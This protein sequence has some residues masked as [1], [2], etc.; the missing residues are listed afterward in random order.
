MFG[1]G[2]AMQPAFRGS[3]WVAATCMRMLQCAALPMPHLC[4]CYTHLCP[5]VRPRRDLL[6]A[7]HSMGKLCSI[8]VDEAHCV[9]EWGHGGCCNAACCFAGNTCGAARLQTQRG[10]RAQSHAPDSL[11][12]SGRPTCSWVRC[13]SS[14][15]A[16]LS[17]QSPPPPPPLCASPSSVS[18]Q[19]HTNVAGGSALCTW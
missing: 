1:S 9:S 19:M 4:S 5:L 8:A 12:T 17:S 18:G 14:S 15:R 16:S 10:S 3:P 2:E 13:G 7:A 11:Q 6:V